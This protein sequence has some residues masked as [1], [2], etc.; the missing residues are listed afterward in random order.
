MSRPSQSQ[1]TNGNA[2]AGNADN[3][4]LGEKLIQ[5]G[6]ITNAQLDKALQEQKRNGGL[7]GSNLIKLGFI[8]EADLLNFLS[9]QYGFPAID[10]SKKE[11]SREVLKLIPP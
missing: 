1:A 7:I 2:A 6:K 10:I 4:R 5:L 3:G 11:I 8:E 9:Q